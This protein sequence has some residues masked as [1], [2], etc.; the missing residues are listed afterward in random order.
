MGCKYHVIARVIRVS[1]D[2]DTLQVM[3]T[4]L[5]EKGMTFH[6]SLIIR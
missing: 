4:F 5:E 2:T 1:M 6:E 3:R